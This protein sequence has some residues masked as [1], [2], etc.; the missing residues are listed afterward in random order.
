MPT[1]HRTSRRIAFES[2]RDGDFEIYTMRPDGSRVRQLTF[3]DGPEDR[4]PAWSPDGRR[5]AFHSNRDAPYGEIYT[6]RADGSQQ[7]NR[8]KHPAYENDADWHPV[9]KHHH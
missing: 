1:G 9:A 2:T 7:V 3:N 4:A 5:I 6:M 8:T